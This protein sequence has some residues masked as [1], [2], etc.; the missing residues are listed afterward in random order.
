[1]MLVQKLALIIIDTELQQKRNKNVK[2]SSYDRFH[3]V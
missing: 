1:M 2:Q 3:I